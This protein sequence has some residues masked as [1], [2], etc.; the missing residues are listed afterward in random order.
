MCCARDTLLVRPPIATT[1]CSH[2]FIGGAK[3]FGSLPRMY[4]KSM[5]NRWPCMHESDERIARSCLDRTETHQH[6]RRQHQVVQVP[7]ADA[8]QI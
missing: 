5:W 3:G 2:S 8:Q 6:L 7:V 4:S 1:I